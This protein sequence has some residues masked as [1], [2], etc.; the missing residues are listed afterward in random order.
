MG[1]F[2][3]FHFPRLWTLA[4]SLDLPNNW[5]IFSLTFEVVWLITLIYLCQIPKIRIWISLQFSGGTHC[6]HSAQKF[7][8]IIFKNC[9]K[10][11]E[12]LGMWDEEANKGCAYEQVIVMS[13][14]GS[15]C[16]GRWQAH[17]AGW[18]VGNPLFTASGILT[19]SQCTAVSTDFENRPSSI[20]NFFVPSVLHPKWQYAHIKKHQARMLFES[21][22]FPLTN[23]CGQ[24]SRLG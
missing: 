19:T 13:N 11:C 12:R 21:C 17:R 20:S 18:G 3:Q 23:Q 16:R 6:F 10:H 22:D 9:K 5:G 7:K 4:V 1:H 24:D 15:I 8:C 2:S 14:W